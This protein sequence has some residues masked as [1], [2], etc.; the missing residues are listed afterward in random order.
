MVENH[1]ERAFELGYANAAVSFTKICNRPVRC[2]HIGT[3][4]HSLAG[5]AFLKE[6][7]A[8]NE[9]SALLTTDI[10]GDFEG[11]SYLLLSRN[12]FDVV[13]RTIPEKGNSLIDLKEEFIKE[14]DNILSASVISRL[15]DNL[16]QRVYGDVPVLVGWVAGK[17]GDIIYDDFE[18]Q[19]EE[20]YISVATFEFEG[21][22]TL[23]PLFIWVI[24]SSRLDK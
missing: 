16:N 2:N 1:L 15:A 21:I 24:D 11:K 14:M 7:F 8:Q 4:F 23:K 9:T 10:F 22:E 5:Q 17:I 19:T 12:E 6:V 18:S 13:T 20:V 3:G